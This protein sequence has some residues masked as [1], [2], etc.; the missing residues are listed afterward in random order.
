MRPALRPCVALVN[1]DKSYTLPPV[2]LF[3]GLPLMLVVAV[4]KRKALPVL[5]PGGAFSM[6]Q[7]QAKTGRQAR[8]CRCLRWAGW[9][10]AGAREGGRP[11]LPG[12][13]CCSS[14]QQQRAAMPPTTA[15]SPARAA[16]QRAAA[17]GRSAEGRSIQ[18]PATARS[19]LPLDAVTLERAIAHNARYTSVESPAPDTAYN[20]TL[21][22]PETLPGAPGNAE[23]GTIALFLP[24]TGA[25]PVVL[26]SYRQQ[27]VFRC[28]AEAQRAKAAQPAAGS[29]CSCGAGGHGARAAASR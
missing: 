23:G 12:P 2:C 11:A 15:R 8:L 21:C 25:T 24:F 28:V 26:G 29:R 20:A 16:A 14:V 27:R 1:P 4:G 6:L 7:Q 3:L 19:S 13:G 22:A 17:A 9:A 10:G 18:L 5:S